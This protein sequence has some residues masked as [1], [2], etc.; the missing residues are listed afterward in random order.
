MNKARRKKLGEIAEQLSDLRDK[1]SEILEEEEEYRD[2]IPENLQ[3]TERYEK[4]DEACEIIDT[5]GESLEEVF[6]KLQEL[7]EG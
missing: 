4:A 2:N 7:S 5:C 6:T 3:S 1:L